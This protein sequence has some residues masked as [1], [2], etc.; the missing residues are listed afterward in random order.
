[1]AAVVVVLILLVRVA[2]GWRWGVD[3]RHGIDVRDSYWCSN[4]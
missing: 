4:R 1:M 2:A 3:S